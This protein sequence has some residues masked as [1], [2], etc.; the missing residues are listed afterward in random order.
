MCT[1]E[2]FREIE[3]SGCNTSSE[4]EQKAVVNKQEAERNRENSNKMLRHLLF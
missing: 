2:E 1:D 4:M 3:A